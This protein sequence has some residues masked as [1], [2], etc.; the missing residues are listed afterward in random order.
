[1]E[2]TIEFITN[3]I[4]NDTE[5]SP[6]NLI[7]PN[8]PYH[9]V[10]SEVMEDK[11]IKF[12]E[13]TYKHGEFGE[14]I[15]DGI[16]VRLKLLENFEIPVDEYAD[17]IKRL[18]LELSTFSHNNVLKTFG[19]TFENHSNNYY[20]VHEYT[21]DGDLRH[22]LRQKHSLSWRDKFEITRQVVNGLN[23]LHDERVVHTELHPYNIFVHDG[24]PKIANLGN[25]GASKMYSNGNNSYSKYNPPDSLRKKYIRD[26]AKLNIYSLGVLMWEIAHNGVEP[27]CSN[28][29]IIDETPLKFKKLY[30]KC[31]DNNP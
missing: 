4:N 20:F 16:L 10:R 27:F 26:K 2:K 22:Y 31:W 9:L 17:Y 21:N 3:E 30:Q 25:L 5:Q 1:K 28:Y 15:W 11:I 7:V 19:L 8:T 13:L 6:A 18:A 24:I 14:I 12:D 23:F 29:H